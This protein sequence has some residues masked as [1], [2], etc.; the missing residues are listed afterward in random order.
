MHVALM[1][2]QM[3][4]GRVAEC[5]ALFCILV[6]CCVCGAAAP[7]HYSMLPDS[8]LPTTYLSLRFT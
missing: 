2:V 7:L 1:A 3:P 5:F 6:L 4:Q 8:V